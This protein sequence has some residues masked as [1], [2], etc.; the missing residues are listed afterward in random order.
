MP[1]LQVSITDFVA[2]FTGVA[3]ESLSPDVTLLAQKRRWD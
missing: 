2:E 3:R 1:D